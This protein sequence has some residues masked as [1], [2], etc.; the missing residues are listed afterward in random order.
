M[1]LKLTTLIILIF[2]LFVSGQTVT[3]QKF[4]NNKSAGD[5]TFS[6]PIFFN[7][8]ETSNI[9]IA[10][11]DTGRVVIAWH[12][13]LW[14]GK[15]VSV[16]GDIVGNDVIFGSWII[17]DEGIVGDIVIKKL[18]PVKFIICYQDVK[19]GNIGKAI[20][21]EVNY[22]H[23]SYAGSYTFNDTITENI[24]LT[25]L[26]NY[27]C[28][29]SFSD[30]GGNFAGKAVNARI[31]GNSISFSSKSSF[32]NSPVNQIKTLMLTDSTFAIA[33]SDAGNNQGSIVHGQVYPD[34]VS[35]GIEMNFS[36]EIA[37]Q[38]EAI[39]LFDNKFV[40]SYISGG[41]GKSLAGSY[42]SEYIAFGL[43]DTLV[44]ANPNEL[45]TTEMDQNHFVSIY[46]IPGESFSCLYNTINGTVQT[47]FNSASIFS[48]LSDI[49]TSKLTDDKFIIAYADTSDGNAGKLIIGE[50]NKPEGYFLN[51]KV[52]LEGP[53]A[54]SNMNTDLTN[55]SILPLSQPYNTEPWN[56]S[57]YEYLSIIP[58]NAADWLYFEIRETQGDAS[59][60]TS[61]KIIHRQSVLLTRDGNILSADGLEKPWFEAEVNYNLF[62]VIDHRNHLK[63]VS[64]NSLNQSN[65]IYEYDF[66]DDYNKVY[67]GNRGY[68]YLSGG[69][70]GMTA[71]DADVNSEIQNQDKDDIWFFENG[72]AGY[73]SG[74]FNLDGTVNVLDKENYWKPNAGMSCQVPE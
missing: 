5:I 40:L 38:I 47:H 11:L 35:F 66:S 17:F 25:A 3:E 68:N 57:G 65:G 59:S 27:K 18:N 19:H 56:Y 2:P 30:G 50:I 20:V 70:F 28:V 31:P 61:D 6:D 14:G 8:F 1:Y 51:A 63:I 37:E 62:L 45:L 71:G 44:F 54:G 42:I 34:S 48:D 67:G 73:Y 32:T 4:D 23:I 46:K 15:G 69:I 26:D 53:F 10:S 24:S 39:R 41:T 43:A 33:Y 21:G 60:A 36:D 72:M 7:F 22:N 12:Q 13:E 64:A 9:S 74:D 49:T 58:A 52:Y 55:L 29:I 16:I